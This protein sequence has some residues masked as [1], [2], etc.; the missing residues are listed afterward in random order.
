MDIY[1]FRFEN[2]Q[3][4]QSFYIINKMLKFLIAIQFVLI[5][6]RIFVRNQEAFFLSDCLNVSMMMLTYCQKNYCLALFTMFYIFSLIYLNTIF[7]LQF[8][9]YKLPLF[10]DV[11]KK[12]TLLLIF[13]TLI[14]VFESIMLYQVYKEYKGIIYDINQAYLVQQEQQNL[15]IEI[16]S[17]SQE[18]SAS[19]FV[20]NQ[21]LQAEQHIEN[22]SIYEPNRANELIQARINNQRQEI[23]EQQ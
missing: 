7:F 8:L 22:Q 3:P 23:Q 15:E 19:Q 12:F 17:Y 10:I 16:I 21:Q 11:N 13:S 9:E 4:K 6:F 14:Y 5:F 2:Y 1:N 18:Q 20:N